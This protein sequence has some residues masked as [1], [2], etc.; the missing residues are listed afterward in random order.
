MMRVQRAFLERLGVDRLA[1][2]IGPSMGAMVAWEWAIEG[3]GYV[4]NVAIVAAPVRTSPYQIGLN[5]L[6]RRGIELDITAG[7]AVATVGQ[8]IARG[9]G[10]MSYRSP[11]GLEEKFG[12]EWFTPPGSLLKE[13]GMFNVESWLRHHGRRIAKRFDPYTYLLFSRAMD[14]HD[15]GEGRGGVVSALDRVRCRT[16]VVGISS[17]NL[18]PAAE[19]KLGA[20]VLEHLGRDV[21]YEEI[22]SPNGHDAVLLDLDQLDRF[23]RDFLTGRAPVARPS[24]ALRTVRLGILGAGQVAA[25]FVR[26]VTERRARLAQRHRLAL[27]IVAV[28]EIDRAK[29]LDPVFAGTEIVHDPE[30]VVE[31]GDVDVVVDLTRGTGSLSLV[32]AALRRRRPVVTPN[33]VLLHAH[34]EQLDR[35]ALDCGVRLAY[36]DSVAAAWPLLLALERPLAEHRVTDIRAVLSGAC[37]VMLEL[38]E[39]GAALPDAMAEARGLDVTEPDPALDVSGWDSGQKLGLLLT[40]ATHRRHVGQGIE[41]LG[42]DTV[43]PALVRAA[44]HLGYRVKYVALASGAGGGVS[45]TVRPMAVGTESHLGMVRRANNVVVLYGP[46]GGEMAYSG[47]GSGVLPV[48]TAVLNDLIGVFDPAHSWTG[49]YPPVEGRLAPP[50]V[51]QW[52]LVREGRCIVT[53]EPGTGA[54]PILSVGRRTGVIE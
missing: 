24:A 47:P 11:V 9:V 21:R 1:L 49:R 23:L 29:R 28:A 43:D 38:M 20:D 17:D 52:L 2:V 48:A 7:G 10:M 25:S 30:R 37:N 22:R 8:M 45:A 6:Q 19:V 51:D 18:Y 33:K 5:W 42:L 3:S 15:V 12:R 41:V 34:G 44:P 32:T 16:L 27:E 46:D 14:L 50:P 54:I 39:G 13:R 53:R 4:D 36:H 35:L 31:R 26:L 40:Y